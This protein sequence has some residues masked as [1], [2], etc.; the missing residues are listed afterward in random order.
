MAVLTEI[1]LVNTIHRETLSVRKDLIRNAFYLPAVRLCAT[2]DLPTSGVRSLQRRTRY[3]HN[4]LCEK[5]LA[6]HA[7]PVPTAL[8][9]PGYTNLYQPYATPIVIGRI[10]TWWTE[11]V[12]PPRQA[13]CQLAVDIEKVV[14]SKPGLSLL[15][16]K[17]QNALFRERAGAQLLRLDS[18]LLLAT[19]ACVGFSYLIEDL[20]GHLEQKYELADTYSM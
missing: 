8:S 5:Y 11:M 4:I 14:D 12:L 2:N 13:V 6:L 7:Q 16:R 9:A 20:D 1:E 18:E 10:Q 15:S 17:Q 3:L 19:P